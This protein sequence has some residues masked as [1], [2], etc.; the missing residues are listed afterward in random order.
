MSSLVHMDADDVDINLRMNTKASGCFAECLWLPWD[1]AEEWI[2]S[3]AVQ[4]L[5]E[6]P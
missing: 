5:L 4:T 6:P 1:V 3:L 2:T